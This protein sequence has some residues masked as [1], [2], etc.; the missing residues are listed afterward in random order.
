M[1]SN[2]KLKY[3]VDQLKHIPKMALDEKTF[4]LLHWELSS[5]HVLSY[6]S[7]NIAQ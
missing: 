1:Y 3:A 5:L 6:Q 7:I 4:L 2:R